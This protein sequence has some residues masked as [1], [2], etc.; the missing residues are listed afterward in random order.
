MLE[1][2]APRTGWTRDA[3]TD[4]S[5]LESPDGA[6]MPSATAGPLLRAAALHAVRPTRRNVLHWLSWTIALGAELTLMLLLR[7]GRIY[8]WEQEFT[9]LLQSVPGRQ[10]VF[11]VTSTLTNTLSVPFL[12]IYV[13]ILAAVLLSGH[14]GAVVILALS[15]PLHVLA[16]FP[17]ALID[18]PRPSAAFAGIEGVGASRA[19]PPDTP[20]TWS[21]S[22]A[23]SP[24]Y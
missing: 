7:D 22:T 19:S 16:Q 9:R 10:I 8:V 12:L 6:T 21:R 20:S 14:R 1:Q 24:T 3:A 15:F 5:G 13:L 11:D 4:T 17:K 2:R 18:R 23:S